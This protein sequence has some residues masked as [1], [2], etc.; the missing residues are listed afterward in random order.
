MTLTDRT[1]LG[2]AAEQYARARLEALGWVF[3]AT[4]WHCRFGE[5]DL[6]MRDGDELVFVEVKVRHGERSGRAEEAVTPAQARRLLAAADCFLADHP[7]FH[8]LIWR[9]DLIAVTLN[10]NGAVRR[11]SHLP[12][13]ILAD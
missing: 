13:A 6:V 4:N 7:A 9:I 3:V 11:T 10:S 5:L 8:D 12:N 2:H 1:R